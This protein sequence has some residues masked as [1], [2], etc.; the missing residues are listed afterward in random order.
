MS[1]KMGG[2]IRHSR[3]QAVTTDAGWYG[4]QEMPLDVVADYT[5]GAETRLQIGTSADWL[6]DE[7]PESMTA[8]LNPIDAVTLGERLIASGRRAM[9][10]MVEA[11]P[12]DEE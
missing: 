1:A 8:Y 2:T 7:K 4:E 5:E 3:D 11:I 9:D 6:G 12:E 10:A